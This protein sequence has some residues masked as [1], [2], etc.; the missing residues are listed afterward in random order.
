[1][2]EIPH[3]I[4]LHNETSRDDLVIVGISSEGESKLKPFV[5]KHA[6]NYPIAAA[7]DLPSPYADIQSIPTT[8][9][10]D[11]QGVIQTILVGYHGLAELKA[12]ALAKDLEGEPKSAP[13][14]PS[15]GLKAG[16]PALQPVELW[17]KTLPDA[18][19]LCPGDW[20]GDGTTDILV[21]AARHLH[22]LAADGTEM[23]TLPLVD[24]FSLI[25]CGRHKTQGARLL[26]YDN[27][28]HK[29]SVLDAAGREI[30]AY[31]SASG[32]NGAHWGD[33]DGDGTDEL[34]VGMNGGGGLHALSADGKELWA[35]KNIGNVWNQAVIPAGGDR[36]ALVFAT[37]AAGT[38]RVYDSK[39][40]LLRTLRP[41]GKYCSQMTAAV[42]DQS[43]TVQA[44]A[45]GN[46]SAMAF[47]AGG[48]VAWSTP[49]IKDHGAWRSATFASGDVGADGRLD[50]VF[51]EASGDLV[52]ATSKGEKLAAISQPT[53]LN[54][55]T[56]VP[57]RDGSGMLVLLLSGT[58]R[59]T[60]FK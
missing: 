35:V 17:S 33:L 20:D 49:A 2:K 55:F 15:S 37:E 16:T 39:D 43:N 7:D 26:G 56:V 34:I 21:A 41:D 27:W 32:V 38:V 48:H 4:Q 44:I 1:V 22:V 30:W 50:W 14:P 45:I 19:A 60:A 11:R 23:K 9:F 51:R 8:F 24:S 29:V 54:A 28:G 13:A 46:G 47:D 52:V 10:I 12:R 57:G 59:A 3:F 58:V 25:E 18:Q 36:P 31:V 40:K 6:V 42:I 5:K 53:G